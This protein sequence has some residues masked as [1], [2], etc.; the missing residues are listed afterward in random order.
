M[1]GA[2]AGEVQLVLTF[3]DNPYELRTLPKIRAQIGRARCRT[4]NYV[5]R[6]KRRKE[7]SETL[8]GRR[9]IG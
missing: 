2:G 1:S 4:E 8:P 3:F 6:W 5:L 7:W 9:E